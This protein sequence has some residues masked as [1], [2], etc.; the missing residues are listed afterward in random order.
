MQL[1]MPTWS[2][3]SGAGSHSIGKA[4]YLSGDTPKVVEQM[5]SRSRRRA[6]SAQDILAERKMS[7]GV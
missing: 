6:Y 1:S 5:S 7:A 4:S 3:G 2:S